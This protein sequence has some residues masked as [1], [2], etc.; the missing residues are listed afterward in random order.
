MFVSQTTLIS[1]LQYT[2]FRVCFRKQSLCMLKRTV[3]VF[4]ELVF[5]KLNFEFYSV[6]IF[7]RK[8]EGV[9]CRSS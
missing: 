7:R 8:I 9:L 2:Y 4:M 6:F 5:G 1:Q 3:S